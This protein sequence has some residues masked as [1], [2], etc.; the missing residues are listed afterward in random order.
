M[1]HQ[2]TPSNFTMEALK[3]NDRPKAEALM[4]AAHKVGFYAKLGLV[5]SYQS[6][7]LELEY[8]SKRGGRQKSYYDD[9]YEDDE[10][11]AENGTMGEIY[12]EYLRI[13]HW[14]EE[15][16]PP[17]KT[18]HLK[19]PTSSKISPSTKANLT[20]KKP[21]VGLATQG[22][23]CNIGSGKF[24]EQLF[25]A[26]KVSCRFGGSCLLVTT[27]NWNG[28]IITTVDFAEKCGRCG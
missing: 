26:Q 10:D 9:D 7:S 28:W 22:W 5:T 25:V 4:A 21:E 2:Y 18:S 12:E 14:M 13:E 20:K 24:T 1:G 15:G 17:Y 8:K 3:L 16:I 27:I 23:R 11:L 19:K 6:G